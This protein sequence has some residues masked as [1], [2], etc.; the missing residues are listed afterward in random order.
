MGLLN[1]WKI[2]A[3]KNGLEHEQH[4]KIW[5]LSI[6]KVPFENDGPHLELFLLSIEL[7]LRPHPCFGDNRD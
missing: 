5:K 4:G 3:K 1:I 2:Q 6:K 7:S